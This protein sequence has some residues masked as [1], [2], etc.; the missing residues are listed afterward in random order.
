MTITMF[1]LAVFLCNAVYLIGVEGESHEDKHLLKLMS[2]YGV[3]NRMSPLG[4]DKLLKKTGVVIGHEPFNCSFDNCSL[5]KCL[6]GKN[7]LQLYFP[8]QDDVDSNGMK[9]LSPAILYQS[10]NEKCRSKD[11]KTSRK[12]PS[13]GEIWG[14]SILSV[15]VI[16]CASLLGALFHPLSKTKIYKKVLAFMVCLAIGTLVASAILVL[17]PEALELTE[18]SEHTATYEN[19]CVVVLAG[20]YGFFLV[21]RAL[22]FIMEWRERKYA[23]ETN[24]QIDPAEKQQF[25]ISS[26]QRSYHQSQSNFRSYD[27]QASVN[28]GKTNDMVE[29]NFSGSK[30]IK[31]VAWMIVFG[32]G[33]HNFMDGLAIGAAF[34]GSVLAGVSVSIGIFCE[35]LPHELGDFAILLSSGMKIKQA[36]LC[37]FLSACTCYGG[38]IAGIIVGENSSGDVWIFGLTGG[39]FLYISLV[40]MLPE[41]NHAAEEEALERG[42]RSSLITFF[43]QNLGL[44]TGMVIIFLIS[45]FASQINFGS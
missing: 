25:P 28:S 39:M 33:V 41:V 31:P 7:L 27:S 10:Q 45:H 29:K 43:L 4:I 30:Q 40:D 22:K 19:R 16:S 5:D 21:E 44:I 36:M 6:N 20:I 24:S 37:N 17:I 18:G 34:T 2:D 12:K 35:E 15:T 38:M 42:N 26:Q 1:A 23:T 13:K 32:D 14:Y 8:S 3:N 9:A 11:E